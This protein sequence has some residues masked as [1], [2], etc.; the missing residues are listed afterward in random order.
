MSR[1]P[2]KPLTPPVLDEHDA[3]AIEKTKVAAGIKTPTSPAASP[4]T[5][6]TPS[7]PKSQETTSGRVAEPEQKKPSPPKGETMKLTQTDLRPLIAPS[8]ELA[9]AL[10]SILSDIDPAARQHIKPVSI[11][12]RFMDQNDAAL[13][14]MILEQHNKA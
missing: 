10:A 3:A 9:A 14:K 8:G 6:E 7:P 12:K 2:R 5:T 13:A 4:T 11:L 1:P